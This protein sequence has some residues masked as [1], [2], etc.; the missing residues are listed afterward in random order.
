MLRGIAAPSPEV[1]VDPAELV[2]I[3]MAYQKVQSASWPRL[4]P[5]TPARAAT[6]TALSAAQL[7][8]ELRA[9]VDRTNQPDCSVRV[10]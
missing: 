9:L 8:H 1:H 5:D 6:W 10:F 2:A 7:T 4:H 3:L